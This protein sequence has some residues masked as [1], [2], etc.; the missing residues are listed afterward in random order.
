MIYELRTYQPAEERV[1]G[2]CA[3]SRRH[4]SGDAAAARTAV[5][6]QPGHVPLQYRDRALDPFARSCVAASLRPRVHLGW[7]HGLRPPNLIHHALLTPLRPRSVLLEFI[8]MF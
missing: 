3:T 6:R 4:G 7:L 1:D 8:F 2:A 5:T